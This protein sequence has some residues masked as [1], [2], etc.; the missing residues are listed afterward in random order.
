MS[1]ADI[2]G[3]DRDLIHYDTDEELDSKK[4]PVRT[5][6]DH[7][8]LYSPARDRYEETRE[9]SAA[10]FRGTRRGTHWQRPL[11]TIRNHG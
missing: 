9:P 5:A 3:C 11:A 8:S 7:R 2:D 4:I 6:G 10:N 1:V